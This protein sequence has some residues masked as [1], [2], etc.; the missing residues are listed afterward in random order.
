MNFVSSQILCKCIV[1]NIRIKQKRD[2]VK[3]VSLSLVNVHVYLVLFL[4]VSDNFALSIRTL[5]SFNKIYKDVSWFLKKP[6]KTSEGSLISL[7]P[8]ILDDLP[9]P[10]LV[11]RRLTN[12]LTP[13]CWRVQS[14][15]GSH[16]KPLCDLWN[17]PPVVYV[18]GL[19]ESMYWHVCR[20]APGTPALFW[21][22][23][24]NLQWARLFPV[25]FTVKKKSH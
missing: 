22:I 19:R 3:I 23:A 15:K 5:A 12:T 8:L 1:T 7:S 17:D 10:V 4:S 25:H 16:I 20:V 2:C 6:L 9:F 21:H 18:F 14:V 11:Q 13:P 24:M